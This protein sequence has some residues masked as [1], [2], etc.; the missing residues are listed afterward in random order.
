MSSVKDFGLSSALNRGADEQLD[1]IH[2]FLNSFTFPPSEMPDLSDNLLGKEFMSCQIRGEGQEIYLTN[3]VICK[4]KKD[5]ASI[6]Y[7]LRQ[8]LVAFMSQPY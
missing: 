8:D 2:F 1:K 5:D 4:Y 7:Y 6:I 3:F